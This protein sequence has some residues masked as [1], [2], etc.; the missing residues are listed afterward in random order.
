MT[1]AQ[2]T[3]APRGDTRARILETAR[4]LF[5]ERGYFNTAIQDIRQASGLSIGSIY[6]HFQGKEDIARALY[7]ET[8]AFVRSDVAALREEHDS[9]R[10]RCYA[11]VARIFELTEQAPEMMEYTLHFK[12]REVLPHEP[13]VCFSEPFELFKEIMAE[14]MAAGE[15]RPM[16][17]VLASAAFLGGPI[18]LVQLRLDGVVERPL[19]EYLPGAW[20]CAWSAVAVEPE[21][22]G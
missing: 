6:H 21:G 17:T 9:A 22:A 5:T 1:A 19:P 13:P 20:Q 3:S 8:L 15:V 4:R 12:H 14:G 11:L 16:E 10:E 2:S 18:R 7:Y